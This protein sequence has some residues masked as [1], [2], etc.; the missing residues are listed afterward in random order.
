MTNK[1][2]K[3]KYKV[4]VEK[5]IT[6]TNEK[7]INDYNLNYN[8]FFVKLYALLYHVVKTKRHFKQKLYLENNLNRKKQ[9]LIVFIS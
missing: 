7:L 4:L 8:I 9:N 3:V 5:K 2:N 1:L 6:K